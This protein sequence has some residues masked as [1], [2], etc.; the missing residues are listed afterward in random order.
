MPT[1][2]G[3]KN[4]TLMNKNELWDFAPTPQLCEGFPKV[5]IDGY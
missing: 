5:L 3:W 2:P 1:H 4:P